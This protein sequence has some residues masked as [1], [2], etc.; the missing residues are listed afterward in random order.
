MRNRT[1]ENGDFNT[2][3]NMSSGFKTAV[4]LDIGSTTTKAGF[5]GDPQP[6]LV[7]P[8]II[9]NTNDKES[10]EFNFTIGNDTKLKSTPNSIYSPF[11]QGILASKDDFDKIFHHTCY[12]LHA[13]YEQHPIIL[14]ES[15]E[16]PENIRLE[17][18]EIL[19]E[20]YRVPSLYF[21]SACSLSL[22]TSTKSTGLCVDIGESFTQVVPIFELTQIPQ[23]IIVS[24]IAGSAITKFIYDTMKRDSSYFMGPKGRELSQTIKETECYVAK[25]YEALNR[26]SVGTKTLTIDSNTIELG[27][28]LY[29]APEILFS[30]LIASKTDDGLINNINEALLR[31]DEGMRKEMLQNVV[32]TGGTT[33]LDG[34]LPRFE[35]D[36]LGLVPQNERIDVHIFASSRRNYGVWIGGSIFGSL[37][38][39]PSMVVTKAEYH[40]IGSKA[41][42]RRFY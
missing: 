9:G 39:F 20:T 26:S 6:K 29:Q 35:H 24:P 21:G 36:L 23:S 11:K 1:F 25:D 38:M 17:R 16:T 33:F 22:Y 37:D 14:S 19:F 32:I 18:C 12:T 30:P 34:F 40:E 13:D 42:Q 8:T 41:I 31:T 27:S 15:S 2:V 3:Y 4:V 10:R 7:F 28:I 5:A